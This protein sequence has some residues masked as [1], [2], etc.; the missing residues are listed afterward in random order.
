MNSVLPRSTWSS[1]D[2]IC[3]GTVESSTRKRGQPAA[4]A[5]CRCQ[6]FGAETRPAHAEQDR[7]GEAVALC[8]LGKSRI[9]RDLCVIDAV[10]PAEP[11][12]FVGAGP[13][14]LVAPPELADIAVDAPVFGDGICF[15]LERVAQRQLLLVDLLVEDIA[16]FLGDGGEKL[17]GGI[18]KEPHAVIE[19]LVGHAVERRCLRAR[20][21]STGVALPPDPAPGCRATCRDRETRRWS[22]A[23]WC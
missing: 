11:A 5:E 7:I 19:K 17:V 21:R 12:I 1:I 9:A 3:A 23:A 18:G 13:Q 22:R 16:A 15:F 6:N 10:E 20:A 4:M 2:L 8:L 14:R